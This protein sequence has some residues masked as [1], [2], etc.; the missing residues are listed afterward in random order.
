MKHVTTI[1]TTTASEREVGAHGTSRRHS[2]YSSGPVTSHVTL[3]AQT[4]AASVITTEQHN[5]NR[6]V[7]AFKSLTGN[8]AIIICNLL[9]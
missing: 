5:D 2:F 8:V 7:A 1:G 3:T 6:F 4:G 9:T